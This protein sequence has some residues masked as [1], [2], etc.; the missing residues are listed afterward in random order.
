MEKSMDPASAQLDRTDQS[1]S[2]TRDEAAGAGDHLNRRNLLR[3]SA[4]LGGGSL[5]GQALPPARASAQQSGP[6]ADAGRGRL[7]EREVLT[8]ARERLYPCDPQKFGPMPGSQPVTS[9]NV[10][11]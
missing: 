10:R 1:F 5:I 3:D 2:Q 6:A 7:S 9:C 11:S 4:L 8:K